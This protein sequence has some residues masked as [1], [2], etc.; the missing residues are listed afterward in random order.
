MQESANAGRHHTQTAGKTSSIQDQM[1]GRMGLLWGE[2]QGPTGLAFR[3][4]EANITRVTG[5][6]LSPLRSPTLNEHGLA[7]TSEYLGFLFPE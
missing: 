4:S 7:W 2:F 6:S 3:V 5:L 1:N